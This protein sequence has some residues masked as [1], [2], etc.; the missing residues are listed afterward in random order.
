MV[1]GDLPVET[2]VETC[3]LTDKVGVYRSVLLESRVADSLLDDVTELDLAVLGRV[4]ASE[5]I[6]TAFA[7]VPVEC[8]GRVIIFLYGK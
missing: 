3:G 4:Y 1:V 6:E 5:D 2:S 7:V 8:H